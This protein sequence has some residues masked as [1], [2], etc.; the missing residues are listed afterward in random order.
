M[1]EFDQLQSLKSWR[2]WSDW[3]NASV[4]LNF[5]YKIRSRGQFN[6]AEA[7][8]KTSLGRISL[9]FNWNFSTY[10]Y[11]EHLFPPKLRGNM[12]STLSHEID[13]LFLVEMEQSGNFLNRTCLEFFR[14]R[15]WKWQ[16]A[17][18]ARIK[19][20]KSKVIS[21]KVSNA[22]HWFNTK[23]SKVSNTAIDTT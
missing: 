4:E 9:N 1:L 22:I 18:K 14:V 12:G 5:V 6:E 13:L 10:F 15:G 7:Q 2:D 19:D 11:A 20:V 16:R 8:T 17:Q 21:L 23:V 3:S